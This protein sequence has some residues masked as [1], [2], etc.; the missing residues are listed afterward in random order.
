MTSPIRTPRRRPIRAL[1]VAAAAMIVAASAIGSAAIARTP[2]TSNGECLLTPVPPIIFPSPS[3]VGGKAQL[4]CIHVGGG[5]VQLELWRSAGASGPAGDIRLSDSGWMTVPA[6]HGKGSGRATDVA[7]ATLPA[8][9][10]YYLRGRLRS[11]VPGKPGVAT[12]AWVRGPKAT[13]AC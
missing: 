4:N 1:A 9:G 10:S 8:S 2:Q 11:S 13:L 7:C 12:S 3:R 6:S 5:Q